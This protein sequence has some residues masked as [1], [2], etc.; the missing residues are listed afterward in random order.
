MS[1]S[2]SLNLPQ[3]AFGTPEMLS[4]TMVKGVT[5][6]KDETDQ[7]QEDGTPASRIE[8]PKLEEPYY[9]DPYGH[10]PRVRT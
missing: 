3:S 8:V 10:L 6:A 7:T 1:P 4:T 5:N 9:E 2:S